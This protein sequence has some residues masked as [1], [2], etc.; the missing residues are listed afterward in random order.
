MSV[1]EATLSIMSTMTEEE[2]LE[3][4][5]Q[6]RKIIDQR[7]NPLRPLS[8]KQ[9]LADLAASREQIENGEVVDFDQAM[10]EIEA[11]YGL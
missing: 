8:K 6:A 4:Y 5:H 9:I 3:M 1:A 11:Q 10:D 2:L 7:G